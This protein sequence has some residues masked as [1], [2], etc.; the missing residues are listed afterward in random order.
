[1]WRTIRIN[2]ESYRIVKKIAEERHTSMG[3]VVSEIVAE[4]MKNDIKEIKADLAAKAAL[5]RSLIQF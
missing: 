4:K 2:E 1:M 5:L 3:R